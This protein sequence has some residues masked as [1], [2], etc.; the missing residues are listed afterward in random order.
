M[1][2]KNYVGVTGFKTKEDVLHIADVAR[3]LGYPNDKT[4]MF[5]ILCSSK[6]LDTP[7]VAGR[8]SPPLNQTAEIAKRVPNWAIPMMHYHT[9]E[10]AFFNEVYRLFSQ[11]NLYDSCKA[12]QLNIDWP[13]LND[14]S[15]IKNCFPAL[16][17][18]LQIPKR[19]TDG[20]SMNELQQKVSEYSEFADYALIDPSGGRGIDFDIEKG[21]ETILAIDSV[22]PNTL[23]GIA[24][25]F[26]GSN[27]R[28]RLQQI[29]N[30]Y[31]KEFFIDAEGKLMTEN[32]LDYAKVNTYLENAR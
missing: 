15:K 4:V 16:D 25:G 10:R 18:V 5:G 17:I 28:E 22:L 24:G 19:A 23:I 6:Y 9:K 20:L 31:K 21:I 32:T 26:D 3:N 13:N 29:S 11:N 27:V 2:T 12:V 30:K 7:D 1:K 14:M 8:L